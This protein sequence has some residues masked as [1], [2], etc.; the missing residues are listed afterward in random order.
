[1][2]G[3]AIVQ[4]AMPAARV[5]DVVAQGLVDLQ[6]TTRHAVAAPWIDV[7]LGVVV[8]LKPV[9]VVAMVRRVT[10]R[11]AVAVLA[12][13]VAPDAVVPLR[14]FAVAVGP[15]PLPANQVPNGCLLDSTATTMAR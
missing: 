1:M 15:M 2:R 12:K 10:A 4:D 7:V 11:P 8:L 5:M 13:G 14:V 3:L 6:E 9:A